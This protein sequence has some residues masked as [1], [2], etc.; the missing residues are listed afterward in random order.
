MT[1]VK[2]VSETGVIHVELYTKQAPIT[3]KNFIA[4]MNLGYFSQT[5]FY[6]VLTRNNQANE[7]SI[8]EAVQGGVKYDPVLGYEA[9]KGLGPIQHES[10]I[11]TG[12]SHLDGTISMGR[13]GPG[14]TYGGFGICIGTQHDLDYGGSRI[15]DGEGAAAFG[16]L[17]KG[18]EVLQKIF[19]K[20]DDDEFLE[21]E[22]AISSVSFT[23]KPEKLDTS[24]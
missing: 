16:R 14:E 23:D 11:E 24:T 21:N 1:Y 2:I 5:S 15:P 9:D 12:I 8:V 19:E 22:I 13:F 20:S 4:Y 6:R 7:S 18:R 3:C 10:T 17:V